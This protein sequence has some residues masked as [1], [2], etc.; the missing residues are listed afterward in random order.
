MEG[1]G[2][3]VNATPDLYLLQVTPEGSQLHIRGEADRVP[4]IARF[5][6]ALLNSPRFT[7]VR[8]LQYYQDNQNGRTNFKFNLDCSYVQPGT[9]GAA[10][11]GA[12]KVTAPPGKAK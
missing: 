6:T 1:L 11:G 2:E 9:D 12:S 7:D 8:L 3:T 4:A 5:I 10:D